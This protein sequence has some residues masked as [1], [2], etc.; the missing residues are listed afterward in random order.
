MRRLSGNNSDESS[1]FPLGEVRDCV[2][3]SAIDDSLIFVDDTMSDWAGR[4]APDNH[5][6][7]RIG[8]SIAPGTLRLTLAL[9]LCC[10]GAVAV[11]AA[12]IQVVD[13]ARYAELAESN[14]SRIEWVPAERGVMFDRTGRPIVGNAPRFTVTVTPADLPHDDVERRQALGRISDLLGVNP[15]DVEERL[16]D[17]DTHSVTAIPIAE[18]VSH[19]QAILTDIMSARWP[20][21][22]LVKGVQRQYYYSESVSSLSH[23]VG[24]EGSVHKED[25]ENSDYLRTD[26]I[27]RTGLERS[28]ESLMRGIYGRRRI[29]VDALGS[30]KTVI[31]EETG[32]AGQSLRL[33]IDLDLQKKAQAA[34]QA[35]LDKV[36]RTRGSVVAIRPGTGEVLALVSLPAFDNNLFA[37]GISS[38][39]Y[40]SLL[41]DEDNPLFPRAIGA[42]LPSGSTFKL[43]VATAALAEKIVTPRTSFMS[44][45]GISIGAWF[46]PDWKGGGHGLTNLY[47]A[48]SES[49]NTYFYIIGGGYEGQVG[50]GVTR[51][52]EYAKRFGFGAKTGID[53]PGEGE[54]F[55]PSKEWKETVKGERWYDGDT[56]HLA[57]GQGDLLVTPLQIAVMTTVFANG[58]Q[59]IKPHLVNAVVSADGTVSDQP[60][61]VVT[62]QVV[63]AEYLQEVRQGMRDAVLYGSAR[64]LSLLPVSAG[65]KTGTAQWSSAADTHAWFTSFAPFENP[66]IVLTVMV[67]EGGEGS[68]TAAPI[69]REILEYYFGATDD[70]STAESAGQ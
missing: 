16:A 59:L 21:I 7:S 2:A 20:A 53:I 24:Y 11:R 69:A 70:E 31:A 17:Y 23:V 62:E 65:A 8:T 40:T 67:E 25:L 43:V 22:Q 64:Q 68:A 45:G 19:E 14:R 1:F 52:M 48:I 5:K 42:S 38:A 58:G 33:S 44:T 41:E 55:L 10:L 12:Q 29:E 15:R 60:I 49:V 6:N 50:L 28:Y 13:G 4:H 9:L 56:Y 54:G 47:K 36:K 51:M 37:R 61:E 57:I 26:R 46:F 32:E 18:N 63:E 66:D 39:E 34:L 3:G 27:G 35:G 30:R